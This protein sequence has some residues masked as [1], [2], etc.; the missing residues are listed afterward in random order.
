[1]LYISYNPVSRPEEENQWIVDAQA[2]Y[3]K[4]NETVFNYLKHV[5]EIESKA[6]R[7]FNTKLESLKLPSFGGNIR[8]YAKFKS[9]FKCHV[10]KRVEDSEEL[11]FIL[12][13]CLK[14]EARYLVENIDDAVGIWERLDTK[15]G[16]PSMLIDVIMD[17]IR[18]I[19]KINERDPKEFIQ[20]VHIIEKGYADL[21]N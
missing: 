10:E 13:T 19:G 3:D 5:S 15:Y 12:R 1:M 2:L 16:K 17:E 9:E 20:V 21:R 18:S 8:E 11:P 7:R 6:K 14:E 4:C